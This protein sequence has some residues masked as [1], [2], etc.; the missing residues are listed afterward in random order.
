MVLVVVLRLRI[1]LSKGGFTGATNVDPLF[2][3]AKADDLRLKAGSPALNAGM[4]IYCL[5][6]VEIWTGMGIH[7]KNSPRFSE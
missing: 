5:S 1:V 2:V 7:L 3:N 4:L 6:I